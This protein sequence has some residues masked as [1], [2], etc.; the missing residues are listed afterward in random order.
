[1]LASR[2]ARCSGRDF[3]SRGL[4]LR[5]ATQEALSLNDRRWLGACCND[6]R[7][8]AARMHL[9]TVPHPTVSQCQHGGWHAR[10]AATQEVDLILCHIVRVSSEVQSDGSTGTGLGLELVRARTP[11]S[12]AVL[13]SG[14]A[15][16]R[17]DSRLA[18]QLR[19]RQGTDLAHCLQAVA[20]RH[21][22]V[23]P[24]QRDG[25]G[26]ACSSLNRFHSLLSVEGNGDRDRTVNAPGQNALQ[27]ALKQPGVH[28]LVVDHQ[29]GTPPTR[30]SGG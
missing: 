21:V 16:Q 8:P 9:C 4:A 26:S 1:M 19:A 23:H 18:P 27:L 17:D 3:L 13:L 11:G 14:V 2:R 5:G 15:G 6:H 10:R 7:D 12:H 29:N 25:E 30:G 20:H 24:H 22:D 28:D